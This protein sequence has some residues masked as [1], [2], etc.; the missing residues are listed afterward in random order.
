MA[1][2]RDDSRQTGLRRIETLYRVVSEFCMIP[3]LIEKIVEIYGMLMNYI[4][5]IQ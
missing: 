3:L 2:N 1:L 4:Q 5:V